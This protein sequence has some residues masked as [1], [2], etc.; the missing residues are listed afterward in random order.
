MLTKTGLSAMIGRF[1]LAIIFL[2]SS[3]GKIT[4]FEGTVRY[5]EGHGLPLATLLCVL[6]AGLETLGGMAL[7]LGF[8]ARFAAAALAAYVTAATIIFHGA[9]DQRIHLLKNLA[10]IGG[11]LQVMAHGAGEISLEGRRG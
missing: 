5:M 7:I 3:F 9:P 6:A 11:L 4:H 2:A 8:Q 1:L 10:I